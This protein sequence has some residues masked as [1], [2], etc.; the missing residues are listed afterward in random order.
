MTATVQVVVNHADNVVYLPTSA[1]TARGTT[2]TVNV[3]VGNDPSKTTAT[4]ITLGLR[5]DS[6]IEVRSGLKAGDNVVVARAAS[7]AGTTATATAGAGAARTG[8]GAP[9]AVG[10]APTGGLG[11]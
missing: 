10:G 4:Q 11:G 8:T 5:G 9:G 3:E 7:T 1:V 2:A 6:S